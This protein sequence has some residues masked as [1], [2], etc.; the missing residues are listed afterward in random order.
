MSSRSASQE[1]T[2]VHARMTVAVTTAEATVAHA[3]M[4]K[5]HVVHV[6]SVLRHLQQSRTTSLRCS[7]HQKGYNTEG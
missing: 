4:T 3:A 2:E 5:A 1:E 6:A 7:K